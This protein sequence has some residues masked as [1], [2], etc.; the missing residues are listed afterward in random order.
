MAESGTSWQ[1]QPGYSLFAEDFDAPV[2]AQPPA[3]PDPPMP[4][5][6][7]PDPVAEAVEAARGDGYADGFRAGLAQAA[8]NN[9]EATRQLLELIAERM[10]DAGAAVR[11]NGN[12]LA[13]GIVRLLLSTLHALFPLLISRHGGA[14]AAEFIRALLPT[15]TGE[16]RVTFRVAPTVVALVEAELGRLDPELRENMRVLPVE[17]MSE[18][19]A[20][21]RWEDGNGERDV[22]GAWQQVSAILVRNGMMDAAM[23]EHAAA[24]VAARL[25]PPETCVTTQQ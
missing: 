19:D 3:E 11:E 10:A 9:A 8:T 12:A 16:P 22:T 7:E 18:G 21:I 1:P 14:E 20:R 5:E 13:R 6:P 2:P 23:A 15:L 17:G 4:A 25:P 24:I